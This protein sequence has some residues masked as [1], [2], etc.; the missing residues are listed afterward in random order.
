MVFVDTIAIPGGAPHLDL[1]YK[2]LAQWITAR[3]KS[4]SPTR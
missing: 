4:R 2:M 3:G 1:A